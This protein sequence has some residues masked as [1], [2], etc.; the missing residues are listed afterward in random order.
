MV[1][2]ARNVYNQRARQSRKAALTSEIAVEWLTFKSPGIKPS[3]LSR[4]KS[5]L[6]NHILPYFEKDPVTK[7]TSARISEFANEKLK[8]GRLDKKGGLAAST[9]RGILTI[10]KSVLDFA[11]KTSKIDHPICVSY[12]KY[13]SY[14]ERVLSREEQAKLEEYCMTEISTHNLGKMLCINTGIRIGELCAL[15]WEDI[16][17]EEE[18]ITI[19]KTLQRVKDYSGGGSKTKI[20]IDTPK[21]LS[22]VREIPIPKFLVSLL[23]EHAKG[24]QGFF[25]ATKN[26]PFIEP[27][28]MQNHFARVIKLLGMPD[29]NF[30]SLRHTYA[31]R[32]IEAGVDAKTLSEMLGHSN[33]N[34]TLERY[35][36]PS[37]DLKRES[38]NKLEQ[39]LRPGWR[40]VPSDGDK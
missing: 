34:I 17:F 1:K 12:P 40:A 5:A 36:H 18:T 20:V 10:F 39:Y 7:I 37:F 25:L 8:N 11:L 6:D 14:H 33:V 31:T 2:I 29:A 19:N 30:H 22:S 23:K 28:T 16:S 26:S 3:T 27:R 38:V 21:S 15:R 24:K 9:V 4:Y 32:C 35:V 13:R